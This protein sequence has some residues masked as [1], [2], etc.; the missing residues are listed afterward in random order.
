MYYQSSIFTPKLQYSRQYGIK[1]NITMAQKRLTLIPSLPRHL[2]NPTRKIG[3]T[4][5]NAERLINRWEEKK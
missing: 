3:F 4:T 2:S 1:I 5:N